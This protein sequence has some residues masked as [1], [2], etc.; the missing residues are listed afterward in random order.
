M[1]EKINFTVMLEQALTAVKKTYP[2][3]TITKLELEDENGMLVYKAE[4]INP[5]DN[6]EM[7]VAIDSKTGQLVS[8]DDIVEYQGGESEHAD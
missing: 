2:E 1:S 7:D 8:Q 3:M 4:L 5:A 6:S